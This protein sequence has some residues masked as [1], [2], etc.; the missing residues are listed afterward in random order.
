MYTERRANIWL[1]IL[2]IHLDDEPFCAHTTKGGLGKPKTWCFYCCF[3]SCGNNNYSNEMC[4][5]TTGCWMQIT[6]GV[7]ARSTVYLWSLSVCVSAR[8]VEI[9]NEWKSSIWMSRTGGNNVIYKWLCTVIVRVYCV[10]VRESS[11]P[12]LTVRT[13]ATVGL[14]RE[15]QPQL[16]PHVLWDAFKHQVLGLL[17]TVHTH[18]LAV[19][20]EVVLPRLF[21]QELLGL[22]KNKNWQLII[23]HVLEK[24]ERER[25][26][27]VTR[28]ISC[29]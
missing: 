19:L 4:G 3:S 15:E 16:S 20:G 27:N 22:G 25:E 14:T 21:L 8:L 23:L 9:Q 1:S 18:P 29:Q 28:D 6:V 24:G 26:R 5:P 17:C 13:R 12:R 10:C 2:L 11:C 7:W